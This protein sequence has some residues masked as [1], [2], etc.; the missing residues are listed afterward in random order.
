MRSIFL[1]FETNIFVKSL[2]LRCRRSNQKKQIVKSK[3]TA[4][5]VPSKKV[6]P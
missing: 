4:V 2:R 3:K 5:T 6:K 1:I